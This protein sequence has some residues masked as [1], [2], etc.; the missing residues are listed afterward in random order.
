MPSC[1]VLY[2]YY[3]PDDVVSARHFTDF[4]EGLCSN[5]WDVEVFTGNRYCRNNAVMFPSCEI[6]EGVHIKRFKCPPFWQS[7]NIGRLLNSFCLSV[8]WFFALLFR[9][10]D[11]VIFGTDP[12]FSFFII[13]FL[14]FFRPS[15]RFV[16]WGFDLY[17][18]AIVADGIKVPAFLMAGLRW[19]AGISYRQCGM[20]VDI[21]SCMR[22]RFAVYN[23]G[24]RFETVVPWALDEPVE[25]E[26]QDEKVKQELFGDAKLGVLYSGTIG[27]AHQFEEFII[28]ARELRKREVSVSFCFAGHGNRYNDL[29]KMITD[30]DDNITFAG[31]VDEKLLPVRLAA[32]D[33]HMISLR[34]G[35]GGIVV[36]SKFFG[37]MAA[38]RPLLYCGAID[39]CVAEMIQKERFGFFVKKNT[40]N[41]VADCLADLSDNKSKLLDMQKSVFFYYKKHYSRQ[42]QCKKWDRILK[43]LVEK[44]QI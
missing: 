11:V 15:M 28:L 29:R 42:T 32:A 24:A 40:I 4:A 12:Q 3:Y 16:L 27:R 9:C 23:P 8:K 30:E 33:I 21:G 6:R 43:E 26:A 14:A 22:R 34:D 17:P 44:K 25:L 7:K 37:S 35:W 31:F 18:E 19:W 5:E 41:D 38:G 10:V 20:L 2:H 39:S 13:P 1:V 36:P